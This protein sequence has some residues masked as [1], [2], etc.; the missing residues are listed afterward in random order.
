VFPRFKELAIEDR[1]HIEPFVRA[2]PPYSDFNFVSLFSWST[3]DRITWSTRSGSLLIRFRD[4]QSG[5]PFYS[6]LG[7]RDLLRTVH[8][9]VEL[10]R[11]EGIDQVLRLVPAVV[12][13]GLGH[14]FDGLAVED[15]DN[16]DYIF[17]TD[18]LAA[19][20]ASRYRGKRGSINRFARMFGR[21]A[22]VE[23]LDLV[24]PSQQHA[25]VEVFQEW[26]SSREIDAGDARA[27]LTAIRRLMRHAAHLGVTAV[28]VFVK[29]RLR[30]FS[31]GEVVHDRFGIIH[32]E[33]ANVD[34]AGLFE[35]LRQQAALNFQRHG[36]QRINYEQDLGIAGIRRMKES[37]HPV[38]FLR[39]YSVA[40]G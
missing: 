35:Y 14:D 25:V 36:C 5:A 33:K 23:L 18:D 11:S 37:Y 30:A 9:L 2:F 22:R 40:L 34:Y 16:H 24:Q 13:D 10:A 21:D 4:Y 19:C 31:F 32:F 3:E 1:Y 28:G 17:S 39:K 7:G 26:A 29:G 27:E 12:V 38:G 20:R 8:D 15:A 6:L